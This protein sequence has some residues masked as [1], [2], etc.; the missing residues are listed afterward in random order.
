LHNPLTALHEEVVVTVT[1][2]A[3]NYLK[4]LIKI[5]MANLTMTNVKLRVNH[6]EEEIA[7]KEH[8]EHKAAPLNSRTEAEEVAAEGEVAE[9][10]KGK[11]LL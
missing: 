10:V 3:S 6:F 4:G 7:R 1:N 5:M 2:F 8:L 11:G 9:A